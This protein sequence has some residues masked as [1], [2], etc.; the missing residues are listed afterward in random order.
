MAKQL[1]IK[2][3]IQIVTLSE[4][5]WTVRRLANK[6]KVNIS[7]ISR[8]LKKA[9]LNNQ[10]SHL[11]SNGRHSKCS[12]DVLMHIL[13]ENKKNSRASLR[14]ISASFAMKPNKKISHTSIKKYLNENGKFAFSP[15]K[16]AF[17]TP[18]HIE[19]RSDLAK[20]FVIMEESDHSRIIFSDE[21][22]F[23]LHYSDRKCSVW[24]EHSKGLIRQHINPTIKHGG[25]SV[26]VLACVFAKRSQQTSLY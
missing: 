14:K 21:C 6:F 22:K 15:I 19:L 3:R 8:T 13:N 5:G 9:N 7:T 23:N 17:L 18:R 1:S 12:P 24:R 16:N 25:G 2:E 26:M 20:E 4:E 11:A 10:F